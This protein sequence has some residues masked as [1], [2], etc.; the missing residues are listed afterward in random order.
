MRSTATGHSEWGNYIVALP[1]PSPLVLAAPP[2]AFLTV[3]ARLSPLPRYCNDDTDAFG[4]KA[5]LA[6]PVSCDSCDIGMCFKPASNELAACDG[7]GQ[8]SRVHASL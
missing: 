3:I 4:V 8:V 2:V 1:T 7:D 6:C 5:S